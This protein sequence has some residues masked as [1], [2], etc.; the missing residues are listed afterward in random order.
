MANRWQTAR[1][2]ANAT[3][4][5]EGLTVELRM[6]DEALIEAA[7]IG[8]AQFARDVAT[9][10]A[11]HAGARQRTLEKLV[12][13]KSATEAL[14]AQGIVPIEGAT[15]KHDAFQIR[16]CYRSLTR[17]GSPIAL[18]AGEAPIERPM[19]LVEAVRVVARRF[20]FPS[21]VAAWRFLKASRPSRAKQPADPRL[22]AL[23]AFDYKLPTERKLYDPPAK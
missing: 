22:V 17:S 6:S 7:E 3:L 11:W 14:G 15:P 5:G 21:D 19:P 2:P 9:R 23:L 1:P 4:R 12:A 10:L 20:T 8:D 13:G 16:H 18:F